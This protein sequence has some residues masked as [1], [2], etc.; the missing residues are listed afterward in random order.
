MGENKWRAG[1]AAAVCR[2][3]AG[4]VSRGKSHHIV[5]YIKNILGF[6]YKK[7]K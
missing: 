4:D 5:G 6:I 7:G 2:D 3:E 1:A